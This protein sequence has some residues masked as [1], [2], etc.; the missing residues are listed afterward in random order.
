MSRLAVALVVMLF[1]AGCSGG[2]KQPTH[3]GVIRSDPT[4]EEIVLPDPVI[5][6]TGH[7]DLEG[8]VTDSKAKGIKGAVVELAG[9]SYRA[10]SEKNGTFLI[11]GIEEGTYGA[12]A[13][14]PGYQIATGTIV[15]EADATARTW[16][17]L[18]VAPPPPPPPPHHE[19]KTFNGTVKVTSDPI[20]QWDYYFCT[21]CSTYVRLDKYLASVIVEVEMETSP[22][23]PDTPPPVNDPF[24]ERNHTIAWSLSPPCCTG[25][26]WSGD[27][28][29]PLW[30]RT[31]AKMNGN[32]TLTITPSTYPGPEQDRHFIVHIT[33]FYTDKAPIGWSYLKG[34]R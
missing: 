28:P 22:I 14:A 8:L 31:D 5:T 19:T 9:T 10:T 12:T 34:D 32:Y 25:S 18:S 17:E 1:L 30:A 21:E 15:V 4:S 3:N 23:I 13:T 2:A 24:D 11:Q 7:G 16:F 29:N 26:S 27:G 20:T 6:G 33:T